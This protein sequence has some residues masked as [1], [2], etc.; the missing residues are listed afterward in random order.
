M[1]VPGLGCRFK[2]LELRVEGFDS[3]ILTRQAWLQRVRALG[4]RV[5]GLQFWYRV[6]GFGRSSN[7]VF[8]TPAPLP[9]SSPPSPCSCHRSFFVQ[10][11]S[12]SFVDFPWNI[13]D[14]A[15]S[16]QKPRKSNRRLKI[17]KKAKKLK[18]EN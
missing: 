13:A 12:R 17:L 4:L 6:E 1:G 16:Q 18:K 5:Q 2:G 15:K 8:P 10:D 9:Y 14:S 3:H 11:S 7:P